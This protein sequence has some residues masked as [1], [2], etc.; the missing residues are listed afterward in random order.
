MELNVKIHGYGTK[1][2]RVTVNGKESDS[3]IPWNKEKNTVEI[4]MSGCRALT[5]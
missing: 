1:I 4:M 3:F 5:R 2:K